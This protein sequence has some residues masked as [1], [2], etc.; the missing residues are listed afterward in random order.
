MTREGKVPSPER[1]AL[2]LSAPAGICLSYSKDG[3]YKVDKKH[4]H[5]LNSSPSFALYTPS[6][7]G[8]TI[9]ALVA[10]MIFSLCPS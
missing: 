2:K 8:Y 7:N 10:M 4:F 9:S 3:L 6:V 1:L 5:L